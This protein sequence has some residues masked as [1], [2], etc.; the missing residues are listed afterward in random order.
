MDEAS[1]VQIDMEIN[2]GVKVVKKEPSSTKRYQG[3]EGTRRSIQI[4]LR[5]VVLVEMAVLS[6]MIIQR[7]SE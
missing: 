3:Q 5:R 7:L 4:G 1:L 2:I 6:H